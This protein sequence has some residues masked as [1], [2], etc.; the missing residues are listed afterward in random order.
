[1]RVSI[2]D[3]YFDTLR[4]LDCFDKLDGHEVTVFTDHVQDVDHSPTVC[5]TA[6]RWCSSVN[7]R[8]PSTAS[9]A[10]AQ[11]APD[12]PAQRVPPHRRRR[13][14]PVG[15]RRVLR[16]ACRL[17]VRRDRRTDLGVG[18]GRD[19]PDSSAGGVAQGRDLAGRRRPDGLVQDAG[20]LRLRTDRQGRGRLWA[21]LRDERGGV[22]RRRP[23]KAEADGIAVADS[24]DAFFETCDIVSLHLRLV[25]ATRG[26]VTAT[27]L[28]RMK[29]TALLVNTSRAGL[30]EPGRSS[31]RCAPAGREWRRSTSTKTSRSSTRPTPCSAWTTSS[32][33]PTSGTSRATNGRSSSPTSSTRSM[34]TTPAHQSMSSTPT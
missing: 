1:M 31:P 18:P 24:K 16:P 32:A 33:P 3:D 4:T 19:A 29:P 15:H 9:G 7:D 23:A 30:I 17:S 11:A 10:A 34:P 21:R 8:D 13:L 5:A 20:H 26:I 14:H 22:G 6:K 28:A 2:L 27:D 12:Q 25:D